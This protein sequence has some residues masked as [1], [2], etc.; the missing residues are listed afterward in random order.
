MKL[1]EMKLGGINYTSKVDDRRDAVL[2]TAKSDIQNL[3]I[4]HRSHG[5]MK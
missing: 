1:N 4:D 2:K 5:T 3:R